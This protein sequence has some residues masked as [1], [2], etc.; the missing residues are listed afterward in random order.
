MRN[1]HDAQREE[2]NPS[3]TKMAG[4]DS[5]GACR[6]VMPEA[7]CRN[8]G[9]DQIDDSV[10]TTLRSEEPNFFEGSEHILDLVFYDDV[11]IVGV[12][13]FRE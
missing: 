3:G 13:F 10:L 7:R 6:R 12:C 5:F 1:D 9:M 2:R 11:A 8:G 4:D